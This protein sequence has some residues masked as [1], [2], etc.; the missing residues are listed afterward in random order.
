M[1]Q[2]GLLIKEKYILL[3]GWLVC[4]QIYTQPLGDKNEK[5]RFSITA[6]SYGFYILHFNAFLA[7]VQLLHTLQLDKIVLVKRR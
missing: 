2:C 3:D 7:N 5:W 1:S 4:E 6:Y